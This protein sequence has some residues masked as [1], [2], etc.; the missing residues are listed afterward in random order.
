MSE[1]RIKTVFV[2]PNGQVAVCDQFGE[3]MPEYQGTAE[4]KVPLT[5]AVFSGKIEGLYASRPK[6]FSRHVQ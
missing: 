4:E 1:R 3:Q 2:F 5:Q 6:R